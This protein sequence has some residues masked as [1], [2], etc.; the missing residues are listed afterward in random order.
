MEDGRMENR[1]ADYRTGFDELR[2]ETHVEDLPVDGT[3]PTWLSGTL[4]RNGPAQFAVNGDAYN[5][6]FDGL[7]ML[8][9]FHVQDGAVSYR[10]RFLDTRSR[11]D[12]REAGEIAHAEFATDPCRSIFGR[13]MS[14][15]NPTLTDNAS[16]NIDRLAGQAVA[17]TETPMPVAFDP[18][19]LE[20]AGVVDFADD[21]DA[22]ITTAHPHTEVGTG[23]TLTYLT[24]LGRQC[25]YH[26]CAIEPGTRHRDVLGTLE[27]GRPSYMHSF[28]MTEHYAILSEWPLVVN[29]L[30]VL[31]SGEPFIENFEW[32]PERGVR[33]RILRLS[34]GEEV[35][36]VM[37]D[38]AFA[39]HHVNAYEAGNELVCDVA[40]YPDAQI[41]DDL[42]LDRLRAPDQHPTH[43]HL[44]RYRLPLSGGAA[45]TEL[46]APDTSIE[47][48]RIRDDREGK[49][50]STLYGIGTRRAD[51]FS[52]QLVKLD[53]D[54]G[55]A[56]TWHADGLYPGEPVFVP[57]PDTT[58]EDD[59]VILSVVLDARDDTSL[60]LVLDAESFT[61]IARARVPHAIPFG[62]HGRFFE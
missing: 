32:T 53:V 51:S 21:L 2:R 34:D 5:H 42:Y 9:A 31:L 47:L 46:V 1:N 19:T 41:I 11:R 7:A 27:V 13:V 60:L 50:Y 48:P 8:H 56:D 20:T 10:N 57:R 55:A 62:F 52:D 59:G 12:A 28:G 3:L 18:E 26:L 44:R 17:L 58:G 35:A 33:F 37:A 40:A 36:T 4:L 24:D 15:F 29:P 49:R 43:A 22:P 14:I 25:R 23:R 45:R 30:D 61:E 16:V 6:W 54:A 38:A 39:F